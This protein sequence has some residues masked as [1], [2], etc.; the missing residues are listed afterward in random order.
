M[1][2]NLSSSHEK[3]I[4]EIEDSDI[5]TFIHKIY[6][7]GTIMDFET[8]P[9][10]RCKKIKKKN[11]ILSFMGFGKNKKE[12]T[13]NYILVF[14]DNFIYFIKDENNL[15]DKANLKLKKVGN[16]YNIRLISNVIYKTCEISNNMRH[17]TLCFSKEEF[18][19]AETEKVKKEFCI[20]NNTENQFMSFLNVF[21]TKINKPTINLTI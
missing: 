3:L 5:S 14:D 17:I 9:S 1:K 21:L 13:L 7:K 6:M 15:P 10:L 19:P 20:D 16:R 2:H 11:K 8:F 12:E 18:S 4:K